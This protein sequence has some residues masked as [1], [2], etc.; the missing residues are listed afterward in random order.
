MLDQ[1]GVEMR[2]DVDVTDVSQWIADAIDF[3]LPSDAG[4]HRALKE[5]I[6]ARRAK[7]V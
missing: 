2:R 7:D 1:G 3:N 6:A 4:A 5:W